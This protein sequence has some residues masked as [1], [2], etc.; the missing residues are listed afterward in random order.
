MDPALAAQL[1][2]LIDIAVQLVVAAETDKEIHRLTA[3]ITTCN[4]LLATFVPFEERFGPEPTPLS[5]E[6][7]IEAGEVSL[8]D[9][10]KNA[11]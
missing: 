9:R 4:Q 7:E 11:A 5:Q 3:T 6:W 8:A 2:E 1:S 10:V